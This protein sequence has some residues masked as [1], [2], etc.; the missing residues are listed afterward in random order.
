M[1]YYAHIAGW[2]MCV[3]EKVL[4]NEDVAAMVDTSDGWIRERTGIAERHIADGRETTATL[5]TKAA[6]QALRVAELSP[7]QVDLIIVATTT[8]DYLFPSTACLVQNALGATNAAAF[9]LSAAC[10]GFIYALSVASNL[11]SSGAYKHVLVIGADVMSCVV[12]WEDRSTCVLFGDGAGAVLL[13]A[14]E[15]PGGVLSSI[16]GADGSGSDLL[17]IPGGGSRHPASLETVNQR[18]HYIRMDGHQIFRFAIQVM[19][20]AT[21]QAI[22]MAGIPLED[23]ELLIPHQAN[24]RIIQSAAK[25]IKLP[26]EKIF[27]NL[28]HYGNTSAASI[29]I[30]LCEAIE[31]GFVK[32]EDHLVLV[33]FG[34]GLTWGAAVIQW[35]V[36]L[37]KPPLPFWR[38]ALLWARYRWAEL[39]STLRRWKRWLDRWRK[40]GA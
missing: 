28:E 37:P 32:S 29:P 4:T 15:A 16:L 3:P 9:D 18:L 36:P 22:E 12:D 23:V 17:I 20:E 5:S 26:M 13:S 38:R 24:I 27:T 25:G 11:I 7:S 33:G 10:S 2:G 31:A 40:P 14:S 34:A 1:R 6:R 39:R 8:P 35:G 21:R 19:Q 30:A